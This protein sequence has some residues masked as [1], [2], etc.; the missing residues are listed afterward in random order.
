MSWWAAAALALACGTVGFALGHGQGEYA[1]AVREA[2][3]TGSLP[4]AHGRTRWR[5]PVLVAAALAAAA[6]ALTLWGGA[7]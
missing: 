1:A 4:E 3:W 6:M 7:R 5:A 2:R